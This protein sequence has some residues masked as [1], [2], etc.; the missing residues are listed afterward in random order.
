MGTCD[1][2][3]PEQ[4]VS[5]H[6]VD[7]RADIYSLGCTL[8]R[9]LTGE[10]PYRGN[11]L[12]EVLL[13]H[14]E[15][16]IPSLRAVRPEVP[17]ELE[18][19]FRRMVAKW[20]EERYQRMEEVIGALESCRA[21]VRVGSGDEATRWVE[22]VVSVQRDQAETETLVWG[23]EPQTPTQPPAAASNPPSSCSTPAPFP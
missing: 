16:P 22:P 18:V 1:Y 21:K 9:L 3:A 19:I 8:Y 5:T 7:H 14:R 11:T 6:D 12:V 23:R 17:E 4:A 10:P 15:S 2:M 20:P 13:A